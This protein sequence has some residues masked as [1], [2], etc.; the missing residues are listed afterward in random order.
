MF[1]KSFGHYFIQARLGAGRLGTVYKAFNQRTESWV[2]LKLLHEALAAQPQVAAR[3]QRAAATFAQLEHPH[4]LRVLD[5]GE[6]QG[7]PYIAMEFLEGVSLADEL[8]H[9]PILLQE[10][11]ALL[12]Q[13]AGAVDYLHS[14]G[15]LH[16]DIKLDNV[17]M[18]HAGKVALADVGLLHALEGADEGAG[19]YFAGTP[20]SMSPEQ[21]A[22]QPIDPRSDLYSLGV[23][24][25]VLATGQFPF[26]GSDPQQ[27][28]AAHQHQPPL[29]PSQAL[30]GL[31][32]AFDA[33][34]LRGL[35]KAPAER[36][37]SAL[38]YAADF[39][40]AVQQ[41]ESAQ[42]RQ[43]G[44]HRQWRRYLSAGKLTVA[45]L[46][47]L[48]GLLGLLLWGISREESPLEPLLADP[49]PIL[50]TATPSPQPSTPAPAP[51]DPATASPKASPLGQNLEHVGQVVVTT[52]SNIREGPGLDYAVI[53]RAEAQEAFSALAMYDLQ[54]T[55]WYL[56]QLKPEDP[57]PFGWISSAVVEVGVLFSL[58]DIPPPQTIPPLPASPTP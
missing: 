43:K 5:Y 33:V 45:A 20:A 17:L 4:L 2:A 23:L 24:G 26:V 28:A 55:I 54:H 16:A 58:L 10:R 53:R 35:A 13:I 7:Q 49:A 6:H 14:R 34:L 51:T 1:N 18:R 44:G 12:A 40:D 39:L 9:K 32:P 8:R 22:G 50:S 41:H 3:F 57:Q 37:P 11:A 36:Y 31:H 29:P 25:Y 52:R 19:L 46:L 47:L 21:A 48:L 15:V 30:P 42:A 38:A 56:I 27:L